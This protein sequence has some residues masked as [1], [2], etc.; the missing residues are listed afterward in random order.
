MEMGIILNS[1]K[2]KKSLE[3]RMPTLT[4][5]HTRDSTGY[6]QIVAQNIMPKTFLAPSKAIYDTIP[7]V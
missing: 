3:Q 6:N 2:K 7:Q 4:R 1:K 5:P